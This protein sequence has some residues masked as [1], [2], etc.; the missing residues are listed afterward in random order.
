MEVET[1]SPFPKCDHLF[2][3]QFKSDPVV[4]CLGTTAPVTDAEFH[5]VV[6]IIKAPFYMSKTDKLNARSIM[7][8]TLNV[9]DSVIIPYNNKMLRE[10]NSVNFNF[11]NRFSAGPHIAVAGIL[12]KTGDVNYRL[13]DCIVIENIIYISHDIIPPFQVNAWKFCP[14]TYLICIQRHKDSECYPFNIS[15]EEEVDGEWKQ[16]DIGGANGLVYDNKSVKLLSFEGVYNKDCEFKKDNACTGVYLEDIIRN[17]S[18]GGTMKCYIASDNSR[19]FDNTSG[20]R[21]Y[22]DPYNEHTCLKTIIT[23]LPQGKL[24]FNVEI[25]SFNRNTIGLAVG[26]IIS[27]HLS[28]KYSSCVGDSEC[29][30]NDCQICLEP[31]NVMGQ[32]LSVIVDIQCRHIFHAMCLL[33][34]AKPNPTRTKCPVCRANCHAV[35]ILEKGV[36]TK[37]FSFIRT[38]N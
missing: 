20:L 11:T 28:A 30:D 26:P 33:R 10:S 21:S 22:S 25:V 37:L 34:C 4:V 24:R 13:H 19:T 8:D 15:C 6:K 16:V 36:P 38:N 1:I 2:V 35:Y 12:E 18:Y 9:V 27:N 29:M 5:I 17:V 31:M 14:D 3:R 23:G 32:T 7:K